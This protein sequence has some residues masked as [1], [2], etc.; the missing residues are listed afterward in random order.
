MFWHTSRVSS[1]PL[2]FIQ[3]LRLAYVLS[4]EHAW[5][6]RAS[7]HKR[8]PVLRY[9]YERNLQRE[10]RPPTGRWPGG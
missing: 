7:P 5:T 8:L 4:V 9:F 1:A 6:R 10:S 2:Y 3:P